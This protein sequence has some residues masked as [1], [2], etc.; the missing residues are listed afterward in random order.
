M[1]SQEKYDRVFSI[2]CFEHIHNLRK[3]LVN[4][5][6][7]MASDALLYS[8]FAPIFSHFGE[9]DH[10]TI[11]RNLIPDEQWKGIHLLSPK[12]QRQRLIQLGISDPE[13]IKDIL[14]GLHFD[15][16]INRITMDEYLKRISANQRACLKRLARIYSK[17]LNKKFMKKELGKDYKQW[18]D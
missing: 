10:G 5:T 16:H 7:L 18:V 11:D 3:A 8:Y 12:M 14:S 13:L 9:C 15:R 6:D 17:Q 2:A 1:I 4:I